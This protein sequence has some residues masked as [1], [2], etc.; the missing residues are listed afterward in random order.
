MSTELL[1]PLCQEVATFTALVV[2]HHLR[3]NSLLNCCIGTCWRTEV[4]LLH[5]DRCVGWSVASEAVLLRILHYPWW[6]LH[7][8]LCNAIWTSVVG[9]F[10]YRYFDTA[11]VECWLSLHVILLL[12]NVIVT[13]NSVI[14]ISV[15]ARSSRVLS[16]SCLLWVSDTKLWT[17]EASVLVLFVSWVRDKSKVYSA[18]FCLGLS[19]ALWR[20]SFVN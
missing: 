20:V 1:L 4:L 13:R 2:K 11:V 19:I 12:F 17:F 16:S 8:M 9:S 10:Y 18:Q 15:L 7:R 3:L 5:V 14:L 6:Q